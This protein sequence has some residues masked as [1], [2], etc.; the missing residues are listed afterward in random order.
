MRAGTPVLASQI[1]GNVG[2]LGPHY[3]GYFPYA[4]APALAQLIRR[5]R[6]EP[7]FLERLRRQCRGRARLFEPR[8]ERRA[9]KRLVMRLLAPRRAATKGR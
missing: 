8:R 9:L 5:C 1:A 6:D 7:D 3:A 4:D 2:M